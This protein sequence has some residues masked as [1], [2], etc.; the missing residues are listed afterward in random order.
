MVLP[1]SSSSW[2]ICLCLSYIWMQIGVEWQLQIRV[3]CGSQSTEGKAQAVGWRLK[4]SLQPRRAA[5]LMGF[6]PYLT[7]AESDVGDERDKGDCCCVWTVVTGGAQSAHSWHHTPL[8]KLQ[9]GNCQLK[10]APCHRCAAT[11]ESQLSVWSDWSAS[12]H[13]NQ[14][15]CFSRD[16]VRWGETFP[17]VTR[18]A[19]A[20]PELPLIRWCIMYAR[21]NAAICGLNL[22]VSIKVASCIFFLKGESCFEW[23]SFES[24]SER[25][26]SQ[27]TTN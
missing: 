6:L 17:P 23:G 7:A 15:S 26:W 13:S 21:S 1:A 20:L 10:V 11:G 3:T 12:F 16:R 5:S 24:Q 18:A 14:I 2:F 4:N 8:R 19:L 9:S 22:V 25:M 27:Q